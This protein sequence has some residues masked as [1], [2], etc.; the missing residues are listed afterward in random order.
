[1]QVCCLGEDGV[2]GTHQMLRSCQDVN[3]SGQ[4]VL[5]RECCP[6]AVEGGSPEIRTLSG[7]LTLPTSTPRQ[8]PAWSISAESVC[9][10][11]RFLGW[12]SGRGEEAE[13]CL[14]QSSQPLGLCQ[15][16]I[17]KQALGGSHE[18]ALLS[19]LRRCPHE[20]KSKALPI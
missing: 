20:V 12:D 19:Y 10:I 11:N 15:G 5:A 9:D 8:C 14:R 3:E 13:V 16:S 7:F 18:A 17:P 1:M 2:I 4:D 6:C